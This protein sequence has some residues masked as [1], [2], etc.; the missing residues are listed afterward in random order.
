MRG[1]AW[2]LIAEKASCLMQ[3]TT[4][5][6]KGSERTN[7][8]SKDSLS[9]MLVYDGVAAERCHPECGSVSRFFAGVIIALCTKV[10][11]DPILVIFS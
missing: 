4:E 8:I 7:A 6:E 11:C 3:I 10:K 1:P 2:S 9:D 5:H